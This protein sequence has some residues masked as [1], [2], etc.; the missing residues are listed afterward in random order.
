VRVKL[1]GLSRAWESP[2]PSKACTPIVHKGHV[3]FAWQRVRC[4]DL[5]TGKQVFDGGFVGDPGSCI[6]TSD[7][8]LIVWGQNGRLTL[9]ETAGRSKEYRE[10]GKLDRVFSAHAWP[11]VALA[12]G[13]LCVKDRRGNVKVFALGKGR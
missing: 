10:L 5:E 2:Y 13:R 6:L 3:Y 7:E 11:H 4:L 8:R 12:D 9:V 1:S